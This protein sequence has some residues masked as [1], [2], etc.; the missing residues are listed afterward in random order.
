M[1]RAKRSARL[2]HCQNGPT[3]LCHESCRSDAYTIPGPTG[4]ALVL[5]EGRCAQNV[6][7]AFS[8]RFL[9][10]AKCA[11]SGRQLPGWLLEES[12]NRVANHFR[13]RSA[14]SHELSSSAL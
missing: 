13:N 10:A 9:S 4:S 11:A 6:F 1:T 14:A 2:V 7:P 5:A 8:R 12:P 3:L